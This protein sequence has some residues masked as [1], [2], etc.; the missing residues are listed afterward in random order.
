MIIGVNI[1]EAEESNI[2]GLKFDH[3]LDLDWKTSGP[4]TWP[5]SIRTNDA[6]YMIA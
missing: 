5:L 4:K 2:K 1:K 3:T 6:C